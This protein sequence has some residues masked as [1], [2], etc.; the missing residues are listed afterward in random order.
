MNSLFYVKHK[1]VDLFGFL[2][3]PQNNN[4]EFKK[5]L[6]TLKSLKNL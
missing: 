4:P 3:D 5:V 1:Y 6:K 2:K